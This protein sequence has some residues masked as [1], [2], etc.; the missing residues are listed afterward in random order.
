VLTCF[1]FVAE[2]VYPALLLDRDEGAEV[3]NGVLDEQA[4]SGR[5]GLA[6]V[7]QYRL[8]DVI[9][10]PRK[11]GVGEHDLW[12]LSAQLEYG[13]HHAVGGGVR[14][15]GPDLSRSDEAD[16]VD[17]GMCGK[18]GARFGT[19]A[20]HDIEHTGRQPRVR[21]DPG[22]FDGGAGSFVGRLEDDGV[23]CRDCGSH[24]PRGELHRVVPRDDVARHSE[25]F[26]AGVD[27]QIVGHRDG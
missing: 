9:G 16:R 20:G 17:A 26:S 22:E 14:D 24:R 5:T 12:R 15:E 13:G 19:G 2:R 11:F 8:G 10:R 27:V 23:A 6:R 4:R 7:L 25:R 3:V 21:C 1:L 18:G